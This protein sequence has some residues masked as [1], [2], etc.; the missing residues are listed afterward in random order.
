VTRDFDWITPRL[1]VGGRLSCTANVLAER[2]GI[3][4]VV[5]LRAEAC[6][7]PAAYAASGVR[8]LHLPT[9]DLCAVS[10]PMLDEGVA[11]ARQAWAEDRRVLAHCQ[12]GIGRSALMALC[13]LCDQG[14]APL[15]ALT[16][17]KDARWQV[18]P[19]PAQYGAW[20][21]WLGRRG[22]AAPDFAAFQAV[23]Y[24]HLAQA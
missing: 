5:D 9:D 8:F 3:G 7:D 22:L 15:E 11:F 10:A 1:A 2:H 6:D 18:S 4:A 23:A 19:S 21:A 20:A 14:L 16:H 13:I 12:H 17:A 24:R